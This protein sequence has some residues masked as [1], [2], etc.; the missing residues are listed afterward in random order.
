[1]KKS[2]YLI[3]FVMFIYGVMSSLFAENLSAKSFNLSKK[4]IE[5]ANSKKDLSSRFDSKKEYTL[6]ELLR[7]AWMRNPMIKTAMHQLESLKARKDEVF[8]L[9][10]WPQ[11][12]LVALIAPSPPSRGGV[13][14]TTTPIPSS[15][16]DLSKYGVLTRFEMNVIWPLYTFGKLSFLRQ[17]AKKGIKVGESN[18]RL[19]KSKIAILLKKVYYGLQKAESALILLEEAEDYLKDARKK[20]KAKTDK[21]KLA[22]IEAELKSRKVQ[23][24]MG[25]R[26][27]LSALARLVGFPTKKP[28]K[29]AESEL[30]EIE[31]VKLSLKDYQAMSRRY[32]PE[33][34]LLKDAVE[35]KRFILKAHQ[36]LWTPDLFI[37]G[38]IRHAYSNVADDQTNPFVRDDF[39]FLEGGL[40]LGLRFSFDFPIKLARARRASA[41]FS[42][43][44]SRHQ[45]AKLAIKMDVERRY[46]ELRSAQ[47]LVK[48]QRAGRKAANQWISRTMMAYSSGLTE[49]KEV[50]EALMAVAKSRFGYIESLYQLNLSVAHLSRAVGRDISKLKKKNK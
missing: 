34:R 15:Y 7:L 18:I 22:V 31:V 19:A 27:A 6:D 13:L 39:N 21:L 40:A 49:L 43:F 2:N 24:L 17:A 4:N 9:S 47:M 45:L 3:F 5:S 50:T 44:Q 30:E 36:R 29:L 28:L 25:K 33:L 32:R 14:K 35:A 10:W 41:D 23:A 42:T 37:G 1:L 38:Y 46:R 11:G 16:T 8:W 12:T 20:V 48:I 26:L